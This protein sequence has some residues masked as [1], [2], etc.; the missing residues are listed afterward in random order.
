MLRLSIKKMQ[1]MIT[2]KP[3][4]QG[5]DLGYSLYHS[6]YESVID[7]PICR[8]TTKSI[9]IREGITFLQLKI[10]FFQDTE[11]EMISVQPQVGF[12]YCLKGSTTAYV[13][14]VGDQQ[15][16]D[17]GLH[18]SD[19]TAFIYANPSSSGYQHFWAHQDLQTMYIHFSYDSFKELMGDALESLPREFVH[20]LNSVS[21]SYLYLTTISNAIYSLCHTLINN[22][23]TGKSREFYTEAKVI[24]LIAHQVDAILKPEIASDNLLRPFTTEEEEK[25]AFC[26]E[27][28]Q[29]NLSS[30]PSLLELAK[31][32][33]L[34]VYRLKNGFRQKYGDTPYRLLTELRMLKSKELLEKGT[35]NV[36]EVA[37]EVGYSSLGTFSNAF[38]EKFGLRPS[39]YK[40]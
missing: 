10:T 17:Y 28:L 2:R 12:G 22:P 15:G 5:D 1:E 34:S 20:A 27:A 8:G 23:F 37:M 18:L 24:E 19:R 35:Y 11:V 38:F 31:K 14:Q 36:S 7:E 4:L 3:V 13:Q 9:K 40:K 16:A 32:G 39:A 6:T 21:G 26:Y 29:V 30:P 33:G 25:L